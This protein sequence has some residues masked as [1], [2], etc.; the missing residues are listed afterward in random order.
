MSFQV[1]FVFTES[2]NEYI[3]CMALMPRGDWILTP[4]DAR[5]RRR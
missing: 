3:N 2:E 4:S 1:A 5:A